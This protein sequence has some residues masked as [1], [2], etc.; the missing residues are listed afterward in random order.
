MIILPSFSSSFELKGI[1]NFKSNSSSGLSHTM[2]ASYMYIQGFINPTIN[3]PPFF[4]TREASLYMFSKSSLHS[5]HI[6][7]STTSLFSKSSTYT[8]ETGLKI[9]SKVSFSNGNG[10]VISP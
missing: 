9:I 8:F 2:S 6:N 7:S 4:N 10:F 5:E 1:E 3:N